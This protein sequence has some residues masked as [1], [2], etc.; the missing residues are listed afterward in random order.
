MGARMEQTDR[1]LHGFSPDN[2]Y[3]LNQWNYFPS[4][5]MNYKRRRFTWKANYSRRIE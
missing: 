2:K 3:T 4:A 1:I 5:S